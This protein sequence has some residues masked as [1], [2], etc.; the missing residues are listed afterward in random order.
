MASLDVEC[1]FTIIPLN[2]IIN[3][4]VRD[5]Q[6]KNLYNGKL[7][8][9]DLSKLVEAATSESSFIIDYL[10]YKQVDG[11][12]MGSLLG[13]NLAN[14]FLCHY[15]EEWLDN[16]PIHFKFMIYVD[17]IYVDHTFVLF[18]SKEYLQLFVDYLNKQH[19]CL[20]YV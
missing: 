12:A 3:N 15:E 1:L 18:S 19:K 20:K 5:L 2:E 6:N 17:H 8:K 9:R 16:C 10:L 4:C 7:S 14:A 11:V 13:L